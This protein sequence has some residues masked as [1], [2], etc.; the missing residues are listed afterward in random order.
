MDRTKLISVRID[1]DTLEKV[2]A[3]AERTR[4]WKRSAIINCALTSLFLNAKDDDIMKLVRWW[5][6]SSE[7]LEVSV[8]APGV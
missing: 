1:V 8:K 3:L 4:Y 6:H 2:E 5:K 7:K